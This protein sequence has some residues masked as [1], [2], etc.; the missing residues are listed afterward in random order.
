MRKTLQILAVGF[1][2]F[3][4]V[5]IPKLKNG[6]S[7]VV[8]S[9]GVMDTETVRVTGIITDLYNKFGLYPAMIRLNNNDNSY[10]QVSREN[11][12]FEFE[13]IYSGKYRIVISFVG[14]YQL[15]DSIEFKTG[16]I[17]ELKIG[18]GYDD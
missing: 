3:G 10:E 15:I 9:I 14:Y 1:L 7:F 18:L 8:K 12:E 6:N 16:E 13:H 2:I 5:T 11:G 4:C 17:V